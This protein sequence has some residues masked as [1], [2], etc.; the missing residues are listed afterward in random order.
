[1]ALSIKTKKMLIDRIKAHYF[2]IIVKMVRNYSNDYTLG[3]MVRKYVNKLNK[4]K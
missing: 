3:R 4:P 1:M 2:D